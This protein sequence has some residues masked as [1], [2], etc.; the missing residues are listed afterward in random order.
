MNNLESIRVGSCVIIYGYT[1][2][3]VLNKM[4]VAR[5][6]PPAARGSRCGISVTPPAPHLLMRCHASL[7]SSDTTLELRRGDRCR[8]EGNLSPAAEPHTPG[9]RAAERFAA[10]TL[11]GESEGIE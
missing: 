10:P 9:S 3:M 1:S 2:C 8:C 4:V 11:G 5:L 7:Y 6:C